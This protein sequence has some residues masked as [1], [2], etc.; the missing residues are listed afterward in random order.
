MQHRIPVESLGLVVGNANAPAS[1][2]ASAPREARILVA[3]DH[4][5]NRAV[6]GRQLESLGYAFAMAANG[7]EALAELQRTHYDLLLTDCHMPV[8]DGY[9]LTRAV[10]A[11]EAGGA[12]LPIIGLSAS[13]LP[14]QIQRCRDS[15]MDDFLGKPIQLDALAAKLSS[16]LLSP[17]MA[18]AT[19]VASEPQGLDRLRAMYDN[20][21]DYRRVLG[22]LLAISRTE[23]A[24]LDE[25]IG[26]GDPARQRELLHR[27]EGALVLVGAHTAPQD[28]EPRDVA[29]RRAAIIATLDSIESALRQGKAPSARGIGD[30][31]G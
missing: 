17:A 3:E 25:A 6:I 15:G 13:V 7:E 16:F 21:A 27:I 12:H 24:E 9:A 5:I 28:D 14:E 18:R 11:S 23:L 20:D 8:L 30:A 2:R 22:D 1:V 29:L 19:F 31:V 4:P 10:R 26:E